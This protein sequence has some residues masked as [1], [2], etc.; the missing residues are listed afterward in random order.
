MNRPAGVVEAAALV[1]SV[2]V[3]LLSDSQVLPGG[4]LRASVDGR[5]LGEELRLGLAFCL[6]RVFAIQFEI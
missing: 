5:M 1:G 3:C 6:R 2:R 4:M